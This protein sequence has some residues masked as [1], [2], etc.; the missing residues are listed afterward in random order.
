MKIT[1]VDIEDIGPIQ[2]TVS[3]K[4]SSL[5]FVVKNASD[6]VVD[7]VKKMCAYVRGAHK[8]VIIDVK[9]HDLKCGQIPCMPNW[10]MDCVGRPDDPIR[11]E[12]HHLVLFGDCS[13][14][15][16][17]DGSLQLDNL[18]PDKVINWNK[19]ID[20]TYPKF[21]VKPSTIY[22]YGRH[23][24]RGTPATKDGRRLLVRI[25]ETDKIRPTNEILNN[26]F[27]QYL[28]SK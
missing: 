3:M 24:H 13:L 2:D 10:H 26:P 18:P 21:S 28:Q 17:I 4:Y 27:R 16:F 6:Q 23:L 8:Y 9:L 25:T 22:T 14:T 15:E 20:D 1:T 19:I 12:V 11:H 5:Q 7:V